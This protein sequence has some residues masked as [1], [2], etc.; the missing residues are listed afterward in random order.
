[1]YPVAWGW[2]QMKP[3][4]N[5]CNHYSWRTLHNILESGTAR[6]I[7]LR[8]KWLLN[9]G[10]YT[11]ATFW[12]LLYRYPVNL[13]TSAQLIWRH[14]TS[15]FH[16]TVPTFQISTIIWSAIFSI[17]GDKCHI[18]RYI[19]GILPKGPYPPRSRMADRA[20]LAGYPRFVITRMPTAITSD[21]GCVCGSCDTM[22]K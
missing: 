20:I 1:M 12:A 10:A 3:T 6:W 4:T 5:L 17:T 11:P 14:N 19:E 22:S 7:V 16:L 9:N 2:F 13:T 15:R 18:Q 8:V 21:T